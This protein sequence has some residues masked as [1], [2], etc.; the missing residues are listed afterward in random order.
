M[1]CFKKNNV[2]CWLKINIIVLLQNV[3]IMKNKMLSN[4]SN[5]IF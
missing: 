4:T 5:L 3:A 1:L 2:I